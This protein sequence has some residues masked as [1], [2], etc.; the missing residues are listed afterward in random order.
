[1]GASSPRKEMPMAKVDV[2]VTG[3]TGKQGGG[4]A[5]RLLARGHAVRAFTRKPDSP[6]AKSLEKAGAKIVTGQLEDAASLARALEG[7]NALFAMGT[8]F[9]SGTAAET[10]QGMVAAD[11]AKAAGVHLLYTSVGSA[12]KATGIP[13][14]D[15]KYEVEKYIAKIGARAS[16][17]AP[18]YFMEN[19]FFSKDQ[20]A[21]GVYATPLTPDRKLAQIA[22]AD[23]AG[24]AVHV[25][26]NADRYVGKRFDIGGDDV[27]G[28][29]ACEILSRVTGKKFSYFQVPLDMIRKRM[30][31]DG[32][33][34]YEWFERVGYH[35][36]M[37]MLRREFADVE[38]HTFESWA[39]SQD[40]KTL[41]G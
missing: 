23:I 36:D 20:L 12:D 39:K 6:A 32:T 24:V 21:K 11:V 15:S 26:E 27:S 34:M 25:L 28:T 2:L 4:V 33:K 37:A 14:F 35:L 19:A 16:I 22:V 5:K 17:I 18:V 40:W 9:E 1:M 38:W 7:A 31:D 10:K 3:A 29:D 30:G 41:L 8:A 13:H